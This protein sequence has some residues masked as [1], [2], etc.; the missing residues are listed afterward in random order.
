[1]ITVRKGMLLTRDAPEKSVK[2][3]DKF[4]LKLNFSSASLDEMKKELSI[5][6]VP[7]GYLAGWAST[8]SRD[9]YRS[10]IVPGAF[11]DAIN[12]RGLS[13]P[14]GVKFL[15]DHDWTRPAGVIKELSYRSDKLWMETQMNLAV[16]YANERY[17]MIKMMG[18]ANFSVG[19]ILQEYDI[20]TKMDEGEEDT[21]LQI[22][23]ADLF[24][25][26]SVMFPGNEDCHN[27][28]VKAALHEDNPSEDELFFARA[29]SATWKMG[30]SRDLP[31]A[32][33][34]SWDGAAAKARIFRAAGFDGEKPDVAMA[35]KAFLAYDSANSELRGSY[36]L[37]FADII[38]GKLKATT[39]GL[40]AAA[41]RLPNTNIPASVK[42]SARGVIDHY[43]GQMDEMAR[44]SDLAPKTQS[45]FE[46]A[47]VARG[48][49]KC[50]NDARE[51]ARV[52]KTCSQLFVRQPEVIPPPPLVIPA[53]DAGKLG[54]MLALAQRMKAVI[55][56]EG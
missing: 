10:E 52:A 19:F 6:D 23:K 31:L 41:A 43:Q 51:I 17:E 12:T 25:V 56:P 9:Q 37:P 39:A 34:D 29:K 30:A 27:V 49:V 48:L 13:G 50:R 55:T 32:D 3:G 20:V 14:T 2:R 7:D 24:E 1:M 33:T 16:P 18:G 22:N 28:F 44:D 36:K 40:S 38:D 4:E 54:E 47:L 8:P 11:Q 42:S 45:E 21:F 26:S 35:R 5:Q 46:K 15:L 53:L